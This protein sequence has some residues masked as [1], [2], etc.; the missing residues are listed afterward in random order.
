MILFQFI[1]YVV[2]QSSSRLI[3]PSYSSIFLTPFI[4]I[5]TFFELQEKDHREIIGVKSPSYSF[6][7]IIVIVLH[8]L[9]IAFLM[10]T[11]RLYHERNN[12]DSKRKLHYDVEAIRLLL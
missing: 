10:L 2:K 12:N 5:T 1:Y 7:I 8:I 4:F 9:G 11:S 3:Y 6:L